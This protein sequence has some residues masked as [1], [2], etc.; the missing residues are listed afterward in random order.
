MNQRFN[1]FLAAENITPAKL[2]EK[3]GVQRSG[4]SHILNGRNNPS[5]EFI[6]NLLSKYPNLS[7]DWLLL[8]KGKMYKDPSLVAAPPSADVRASMSPTDEKTE[9][10]QAGLLDPAEPE[11]NLFDSPSAAPEESDDDLPEE[12]AE[13][14]EITRQ[15]QERIPVNNETPTLGK[16][17]EKSDN[18][19][20]NKKEIVRITIFYADGSYEEH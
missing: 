16:V 3:L 1:Q 5:Y 12:P 8:G 19:L 20:N 7:A 2:A 14:H 13:Y 4:L 18:K 17:S 11:P 6:V 9:E 15:T 10:V